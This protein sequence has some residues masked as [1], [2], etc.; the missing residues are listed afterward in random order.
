MV[1]QFDH[2]T[3]GIHDP[4]GQ[5]SILPPPLIDSDVRY[6]GHNV[7]HAVV[8]DKTRAA[9]ER[10]KNL[11]ISTV[12]RSTF[13]VDQRHQGAMAKV[14]QHGDYYEQ[15]NFKYAAQNNININKATLSVCMWTIYY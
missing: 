10:C 7:D 9:A 6:R 8:I 4:H 13:G 5:P 14:Y 15:P 11:I 3:S 12:V 1:P 2:S